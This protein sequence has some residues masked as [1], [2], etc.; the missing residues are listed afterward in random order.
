MTARHGTPA[1][2]AVAVRGAIGEISIDEAESAIRLYERDW[3]SA[4]RKGGA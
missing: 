3:V 1:V 4:K 2:F